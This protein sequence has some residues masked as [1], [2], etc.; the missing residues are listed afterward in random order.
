[1]AILSHRLLAVGF[2]GV[3]LERLRRL[4]ARITIAAAIL[5]PDYE[6]TSWLSFYLPD[7]PPV[8]QANEAQRLS[9]RFR[10]R[11]PAL[12]SRPL[13]YVVEPRLDRHE[14][15]GRAFF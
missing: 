2:D 14:E 11:G 15:L 8:I 6:T 7:H 3:A 9:G 4:G 12:L 5:T 1:M 13:L 10:C